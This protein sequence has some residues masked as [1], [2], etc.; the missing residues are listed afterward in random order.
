MISKHLVTAFTGIQEVRK[1]Y[2]NEVH[3]L[4]DI[5]AL[6]LQR[7]KGKLLCTTG[8]GA[9][10]WTLQQLSFQDGSAL[11]KHSGTGFDLES[12]LPPLQ[13]TVFNV[14]I[15]TTQEVPTTDIDGVVV[16]F[17]SWPTQ[18]EGSRS[19][20]EVY[21]ATDPATLDFSD[22]AGEGWDTKGL[23]EFALPGSVV[24]TVL[25][26][27]TKI[28]W[29]KPW[30]SLVLH[31]INDQVVHSGDILHLIWNGKGTDNPPHFSFVVTV[32]KDTVV[33]GDTDS[34]TFQGVTGG[35]DNASQLYNKNGYPIACV[36]PVTITVA[37]QYSFHISILKNT[38]GWGSP[39]NMTIQAWND[40]LNV[41]R[42]DYTP[43]NITTITTSIGTIVPSSTTPLGWVDGAKTISCT[44][45]GGS[46]LQNITLDV[47]DSVLTGSKSLQI[48]SYP[49][50]TV[51]FDGNWTSPTR[52]VMAGTYILKR[53]SADTYT[54][55]A[56][57]SV[58]LVYLAGSEKW[59]AKVRHV[60]PLDLYGYCAKGEYTPPTGKF[61][62]YTEVYVS[63]IGP[64]S[65]SGTKATVSL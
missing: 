21:L 34:L 49:D 4:T 20:L 36:C 26:G 19:N 23:H 14:P 32:D 16:G 46:G 59:L 47:T 30:L 37:T 56:E 24:D 15:V 54:C 33:N 25:R 35:N 64:T 53:V 39:F 40:T 29:S 45:S 5:N 2:I 9:S 51:T 7:S 52:S 58:S 65:Y 48:D 13:G 63:Y 31:D 8:M 3:G 60:A 42:T 10:I 22:S 6:S 41:A 50:I 55:D 11:I 61:G 28:I 12:Y 1:D 43:S 17:P 27:W 62:N 44:V 18:G 57:P 38:L